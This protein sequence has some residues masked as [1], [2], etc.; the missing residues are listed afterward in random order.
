MS[1]REWIKPRL[2][3]LAMRQ[4]NDLRPETVEP[5]GGEVLEVGFGTA[6]N[7]ALYGPEVRSV[8]GV[9]PMEIQHVES[10]TRRI[11]EASFPVSHQALRADGGLP[12]DAGRFDTVITTWTLCSIPDAKAALTEMRRVLKPGGRYLFIE[13]GRAPSEGTARW[14]DRVNP[15]WNRIADGCNINR[16]IDRIVEDSGFE[17]SSLD[18]FRGRGPGLFA[19]MFRGVAIRQT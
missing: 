15:L 14:Q 9:D 3:D 1:I 17:L 11:A 4:M 12:F 6:L 8:T 7:L 5:A 2:Q 18:R 19:H 13:H 16:Q 10:V